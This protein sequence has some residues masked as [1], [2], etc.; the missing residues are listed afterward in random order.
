M[1]YLEF[2]A[3]QVFDSEQTTTWAH[4]T[5]CAREIHDTR[6][7]VSLKRLSSISETC[8]LLALVL[9]VPDNGM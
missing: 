2:F 8:L 9:T 6:G 5:C 3:C 4:F 7:T 1:E